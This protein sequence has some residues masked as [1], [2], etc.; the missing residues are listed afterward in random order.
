V[1]PLITGFG[2]WDEKMKKIFLKNFSIFS[3]QVENQ[4]IS[5]GTAKRETE[6]NTYGGMICTRYTRFIA[7]PKQ[8]II[9]IITAPSLSTERKSLRKKPYRSVWRKTPVGSIRSIGT[10]PAQ[11]SGRS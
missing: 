11:Q 1:T 2:T 9:A 7:T 5:R 10:S 8:G 3:S 4:L 6:A